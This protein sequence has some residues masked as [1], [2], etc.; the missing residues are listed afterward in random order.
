MGTRY[1]GARRDARALDTFVKLARA[2]SAV[3]TRLN[4]VLAC[5]HGLTESQLGVLEALYHLGPLSQAQLGEKLLTSA[6]NL[7]TVVRNLERDG[8]IRRE[9]DDRDARIQM[10]HLTTAGRRLIRRIFPAHARR[11]AHAMDA[12][13]VTEQR[14]LARLCRKLGRAQNA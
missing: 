3:S 9:R 7:T 4:R 6:S 1:S 5:R 2:S 14:Q 11:I 8:L 10:V 12:L 13:T